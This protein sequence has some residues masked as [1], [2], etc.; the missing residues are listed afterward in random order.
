MTQVTLSDCIDLTWRGKLLASN[1]KL[2]E[3]TQSNWHVSA[4]ELVNL[5]VVI[6]IYRKVEWT[7]IPF[8]VRMSLV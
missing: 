7:N 8:Q 1:L 3:V 6:L 2:F 5:F 4:P